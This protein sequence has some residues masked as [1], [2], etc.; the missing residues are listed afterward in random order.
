MERNPNRLTGKYEKVSVRVIHDGDLAAGLSAAAK[1][2]VRKSAMA[3]RAAASTPVQASRKH[4]LVTAAPLLFC[5]T[6]TC[7]Y[8]T[9]TVH[10]PAQSFA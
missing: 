5:Q 7:H 2:G 10:P 4:Q 6:V 8:Y 1:C 3:I 9:R